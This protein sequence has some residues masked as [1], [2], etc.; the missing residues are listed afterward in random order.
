MMTT[1]NEISSA[2]IEQALMP[3]IPTDKA[4]SSKEH[5]RKDDQAEER[6]TDLHPDGDNCQIVI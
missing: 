4:Q 1:M 5:C 3:Y 2:S 6:I